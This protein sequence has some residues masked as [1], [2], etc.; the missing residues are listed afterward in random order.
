MVGMESVDGT[1][2]ARGLSPQLPLLGS[3]VCAH[4]TWGLPSAQAHDQQVSVRCTPS[5]VKRD[6]R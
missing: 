1:T 5:I 4:P 6:C 3:A 2:Q